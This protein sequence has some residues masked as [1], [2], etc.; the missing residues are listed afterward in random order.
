LIK[1]TIFKGI[2]LIIFT[3]VKTF[4][5]VVYPRPFRTFHSRLFSKWELIARILVR[6]FWVMGSNLSFTGAKTVGQ[7]ENG[8]T[9]LRLNRSSP[10]GAKGDIISLPKDQVIF[11]CI[12][13]KA[14][15]EL[16]ECK[17]LSVGISRLG[18]RGIS[19]I[20]M[21][22]VGANT[23]LISLQTLNMSRTLVDLFAFEP[24]PRHA[25]AIEQ[26]LGR[27]NNRITINEF[28]LSDRNGTSIIYTE[29]ANHGNSSLIKSSARN[30]HEDVV[31]NINL[32]STSEYFEM[33]LLEY[34]GFVIKSDA[35]GMDAQILSRIPR[36]IWEQTERAVVEI[37]AMP[38]IMESDIDQ[39]LDLW[40]SFE[41]ISWSPST[42]DLISLE[43]VSIFW[44]SKDGRERNLFLSRNQ[45]Q[46]LQNI[47]V[48]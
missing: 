28:A 38:E 4:A 12:K 18:S 43:E 11:D 22:D 35:Q 7:L 47:H 19:R 1:T 17:F 27:L 45:S 23:G 5:P 26:N 16:K 36:K 34:D 10:L 8:N 2:Q 29:L 15:W 9:L 44:K 42:Q 31:T 20:A 24:I 25:E 13:L 46:P 6:A 30:S 37:W 39:A 21:V 40:R 3:Q 14:K 32:V 33:N 41:Y 48:N